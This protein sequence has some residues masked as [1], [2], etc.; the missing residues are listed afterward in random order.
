[1]SQYI[2]HTPLQLPGHGFLIASRQNQAA[3][4]K[5]PWCLIGCLR[6]A[7]SFATDALQFHGLRAVRERRRSG[8][9][10]E[11]PGRR[12]QHEHSMA[13]LRDSRIQ[14]EARASV[15]AGFFG[16][17]VAD[18]PGATTAADAKLA[19]DA[20]ALPEAKPPAIYSTG[21][22]I[23]HAATLFSSAPLLK[24]LDLSPEELRDLFGSQ[25]RHSEVD[26]HG[27]PAGAFFSW[28]GQSCRVAREGAPGAAAPRPFVAHG[29]E[30][31]S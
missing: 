22:E 30:H 10:G 8:A 13:V 7:T 15:S 14:L 27:T 1:M 9:P 20:L 29:P 4:G 24:A 5:H 21:E 6:E 31:N 25:W 23:P 19:T 16:T 18:H 12:L 11:L 26:E 2:D 28:H 17:Y 3:D